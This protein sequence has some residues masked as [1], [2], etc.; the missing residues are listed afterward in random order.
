MWHGNA[1]ILR[2]GNK[3]QRC[4]L[5][6]YYRNGMV[7]CGSHEEELE[8]AKIYGSKIGENL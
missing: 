1:P 5:V 6:F 2:F 3:A 8:R 7:Q 4:S